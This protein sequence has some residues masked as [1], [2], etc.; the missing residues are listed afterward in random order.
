MTRVN[1]AMYLG[2]SEMD[3]QDRDWDRW[4]ELLRNATVEDVQRV[5]RKYLDLE[6]IVEVV[7]R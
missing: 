6:N 1:Q 2:L 5:G 7:V 4:S 3:Y